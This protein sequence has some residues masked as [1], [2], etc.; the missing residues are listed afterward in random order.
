MLDAGITVVVAAGNDGQAAMTGGSPGTGFGSLTVGAANTVVHERVLRDNQFGFGAGNVYR[1]SSHDQTAYFSARGPTADG[2]LDP[3]I[4][5]NGFASFGQAFVALTAAGGV[6]DCREPAA[7]PGTCAARLLFISGTSFS[8]P[9]TAGAAAVLRGAHP[10][11]SATQ[12][13]NALQQSAN[14]NLLGDDS[15]PIDQGNGF[16]DVA[17]ADALLT[18]GQ[19]SSVIPTFHRPSTS[20]MRA[21]TRL[22]PAARA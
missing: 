7:L 4:V 10:T 14:P 3:D 5:A 2:R 17:A 22:A 18:A 12:I 8:S 19:V 15:T 20:R 21:R 1:A 13:R 16:L 9:T 6:V 11:S